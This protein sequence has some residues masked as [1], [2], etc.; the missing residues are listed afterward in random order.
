MFFRSA[1]SRGSLAHGDR[2][3]PFMKAARDHGYPVEKHFYQTADHHINC[4]FRIPGPKQTSGPAVKRPVVLM[5]HGLNDSSSFAL[6]EGPDSLALFFAEAGFDVWL[7]NTR[8]NLYS[9]NHKFLDAESDQDFW[10]FS[11]QELGRY[12]APAVIDYVRSQT[13]NDSITY[14]GH[15]QGGSQILSGLDEN[16][17]FF[18]DRVNLFL[19]TGPA[20]RLDQCEM[21]NLPLMCR[22]NEMNP[23]L[24][25]STSLLS[26][27]FAKMTAPFNLEYPA[28]RFASDSDPSKCSDIG[29][30]NFGGHY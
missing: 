9:R 14:L 11:F 23:A 26:P 6:H 2:Y 29:L 20:S 30:H 10:Q 27:R 12:D 3:K 25:Q 7:N 8:G 28:I 21:I 4:V 1:S 17:K 5:Q 18:K 24:C 19:L 13:K 15:S 22:L 16:E